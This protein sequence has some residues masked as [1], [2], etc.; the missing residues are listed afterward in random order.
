MTTPVGVVG[1]CVCIHKQ[2]ESL[3]L[4]AL[5]EHTYNQRG[6]KLRKHGLKRSREE[7]SS[8]AK[9]LKES[10]LTFLSNAQNAFEAFLDTMR[11]TS[12]L[13]PYSTVPDVYSKLDLS[14]CIIENKAD[15]FVLENPTST[16]RTVCAFSSVYLMPPESMCMMSDVSNISFVIPTDKYDVIVVDP[17]WDNKSVSRG[18]LYLHMQLEDIES[19]PVPSF[20]KPIGGLVFIWVTNDPRLRGFIIN[21]LLA[22]WGLTFHG[23]W[24]WLKVGVDGRLRD[25]LETPHRKPYEQL[26]VAYAGDRTIIETLPKESV[27]WAV[28]GQHSRKPNLDGI[29]GCIFKTSNND[30]SSMSK[31][32]LF[33][34]NLTKGWDSW[35]NEP[36]K[37]NDASYFGL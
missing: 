19:M 7:H 20:L 14:P 22:K 9:P 15:K 13:F 29:L 33:A 27:I 10:E 37:G 2:I 34:R 3:G 21:R 35:G 4:P 23:V 28:P 24:Y 26:V 30:Y 8:H 16:V 18:N 36:L 5:S 6:V 12:I 1:W 31:L 17:P 32:E 11:S 25:P